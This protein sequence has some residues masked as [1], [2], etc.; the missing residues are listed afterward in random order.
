MKL[1]TSITRRSAPGPA[2]ALHARVSVSPSTRSSWRTCPNVN[3][4]RNLPS[5]EGAATQPPK[6]RR[7]RPERSTSASS[8][9]SAPSAIANTRL[10]TF[11]PALRAPGRSGR[12]RTNR[13]TRPSI[14]N[15]CASVAASATPASDTTRSSSKTTRTRSSP[16]GPSSCTIKVTSSA[17]PR[18]HIQ[19][20]KAPL[21]RSFLLQHRTAS[22]HHRGGSRL[23]SR[24]TGGRC[25]IELSRVLR[26]GGRIR[27]SRS[28]VGS[29][30]C[31]GAPERLVGCDRPDEAGELAGAGDDDLLLRLAAAGHPL[32]ALEEPLL[33]A[34]G[35]L[36]H[37]R[38]LA[39]LAAGELVAELRPPARVPGGL[40]QQAADA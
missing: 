6:R 16:T 22:T 39:A 20:G 1:S 7:V 19:L 12:N 8:M 23:R 31:S 29:V 34:P 11:R 4:R 9:L 25:R 3:A 13:S 36:D 35:S 21:R 40:D 18:L 24:V 5:V 37:D 17:G 14:P 27:C 32:P 2:P 28:R 10:I 33:A 30:G 26:V 15:R 38:V